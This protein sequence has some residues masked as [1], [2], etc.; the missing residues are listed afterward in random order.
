METC[1]ETEPHFCHVCVC[2]GG[3]SSWLHA[4]SVNSH[5]GSCCLFTA[6]VLVLTPLPCSN[7]TPR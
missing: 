5:Y 6:C 3:G 1:M 7:T 2:V 4:Q